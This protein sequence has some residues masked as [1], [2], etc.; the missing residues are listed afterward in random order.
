MELKELA[1]KLREMPDTL[2]KGRKDLQGL[3]FGIRYAAELDDAAKQAGCSITKTIAKIR[4]K[5][6]GSNYERDIGKGVRLA[7]AKYVKLE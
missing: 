4:E 7:L 2:P 6:G 3:L 1:D 5:S